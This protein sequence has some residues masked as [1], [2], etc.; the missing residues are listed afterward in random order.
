MKAILA[1]VD[2]SIV[3][4]RVVDAAVK[5]ARTTHANVILLHV[6]PKPSVFRNVLPAIEDVK[7]RTQAEAHTAEKQMLAL[8]KTFRRRLP[9]IQ[10]AYLNGPP[11]KRIVEEARNR[12]AAYIVLGSHGHSALRDAVLG[13]VAAAVVK[14]ATCPV[15]VVPP[16]QATM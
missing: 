9:K 16:V 14:T 15:L 4:A 5:L 8:Q 3:T 7:T 12:K 2:F 11:A 13:S 6:V 1:P 10:I